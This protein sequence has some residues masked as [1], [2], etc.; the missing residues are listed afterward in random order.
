MTL[1]LDDTVFDSTNAT[2]SDVM[3]AKDATLSPTD[4]FD[5]DSPNENKTFFDDESVVSDDGSIDTLIDNNDLNSSL[6]SSFR[7]EINGTEILGK[8]K[9]VKKTSSICPSIGP[10]MHTTRALGTH[11]CSTFAGPKREK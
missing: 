2:S 8:S 3:K 10:S 4:I 5:N 6:N 9:G 11:W 7:S 1:I